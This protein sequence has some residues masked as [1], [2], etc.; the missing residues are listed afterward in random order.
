MLELSYGIGEGFLVSETIFKSFLLLSGELFLPYACLL[1]QMAIFKFQI[2][3]F[4][5]L[6]GHFDLELLDGLHQCSFLSLLVREDT[7]HIPLGLF[8][9]LRQ[10]LGQ[11]PVVNE[12]LGGLALLCLCRG[13]SV[14][15]LRYLCLKLLSLLLHQ[16]QGML[17]LPDRALQ[18]ILASYELSP[19]FRLAQLRNR[20][21]TLGDFIL[22]MLNLFLELSH[23][24][25]GQVKAPFIVIDFT[26]V[27][28]FI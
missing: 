5:I 19:A 2:G 1:L 22:K 12:L 8:Q 11:M 4:Q 13:F 9:L 7:V 26:G 16:H 20:V 28:D 18:L 14:L 15:M 10:I 6:L 23:L 27:C 25:M 3:D 21:I 17:L 24:F